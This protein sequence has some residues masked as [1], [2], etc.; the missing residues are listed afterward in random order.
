MQAKKKKKES[1]K[2]KKQPPVSDGCNAIQK[3]KM[4]KQRLNRKAKWDCGY[5]ITLKIKCL[6][7]TIMNKNI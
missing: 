2:G 5:K 7:N 1:N 6:E 3:Y 4:Q